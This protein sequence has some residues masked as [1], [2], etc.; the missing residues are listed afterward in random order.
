MAMKRPDRHQIVTAVLV[1]S[2]VVA[3]CVIWFAMYYLRDYLADVGFARRPINPIRNYVLALQVYLPLWLV[4]EWYY[5]NF[6]HRE[7]LTGLNQLSRILKTFI[8]GL[9]GSLAFAYLFKQWDI[10]RFILLGSSFLYFWWLYVSR[11]MLKAWKQAQVLKGVGVINV[12]VIGVGRTARRVMDRIVNHPEGGYRLVGFV[13]PHPRRPRRAI[14]GFPV[15]GSTRELVKILQEHPVEQVFL[16]V[17]KMPQNEMMNLIVQCE[18]MGVQFKIVTNLFEVITS[19][20]RIDVIDEVPV[21]HL[22]NAELPFVQA[23]LKRALDIVVASTLLVLFAPVMVGIA[24]AIR[25]DS[26]GPALFKQ[27]RVGQHGRLFEM[28]KFRTMHVDADPYAPAPTDPNDPRI[29]RIGRW[30]RRY[31]LDEFPQLI[32]VLRGEMSMVG[33]RPE[34]PFLVEQYEEWQRRRLDVKPGVTGLWQIVG[35]KNLP[36]SLNLEYD[37]Y[38]IKN[39]SLF[40]DIVILLKTIPAVIFGKG[41]F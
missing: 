27:V 21:I 15:L 34:M 12:L 40:F 13:D 32:N 16:A 39:Q 17:P 19:Q 5:G 28:Y 37:F 18:D 31:S 35:R 23:V 22:R 9:I 3:F 20:V 10:G 26:R 24:I 25:L 2:D 11:S 6:D 14:N 30:L 38:Y 41:A 1:L 8:A 7:K 29:T 4:C 36:L 33:P